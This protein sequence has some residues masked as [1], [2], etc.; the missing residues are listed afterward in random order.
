M[1]IFGI[2][3]LIM[4]PVTIAI[5]LLSNYEVSK[6]QLISYKLLVMLYIIDKLLGL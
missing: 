4:I 5:D 1:N 6:V 2:L 3:A